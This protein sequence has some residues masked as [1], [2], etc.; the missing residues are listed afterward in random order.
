MKDGVVR[1]NVQSRRWVS[2]QQ[3]S[4]NGSNGTYAPRDDRNISRG[5]RAQMKVTEGSR[6]LL[7][8]A[9]ATKD[10]KVGGDKIP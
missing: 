10:Y 5:E 1:F 6:D 2:M 3:R 8:S 9:G 4:I 7:V